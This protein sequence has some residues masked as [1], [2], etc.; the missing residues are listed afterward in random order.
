MKEYLIFNGALKLKE[1]VKVSP[2]N[3]GMMYGDGFFD[4]LRSYQG[5]FLLLENHFQR[6]LQTASY[7]GIEVHFGL[8]DFKFKI[9]ELLEANE[10]LEKEILVRIQ[11]WR[12]G[13]RGY[14]PSSTNGNWITSSALISSYSEF[15][16]LSL[17]NTRIIPNR[18]L[19]REFKLS[20]G[21][22]YIQ[23]AREA[24]KLGADDGIMLTIDE[25]I[26]ETTSANLFWVKGNTV[27]TPSIGCDL[28][29][30]I[31]RNL[32]VRLVSENPE[33]ELQEGEFNLEELMSAEAVFTTNSIREIR[34]VDSINETKFSIT[35]N[36]LSSIN[37]LF[38][39]FK[40]QDLK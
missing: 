37:T 9:L 40:R 11:C 38:E 20:N 3:R 39:G 33:L 1:E 35:H 32:I 36:T 18:A 4:T 22:N 21:L 16:K 29:P 8:E 27:Y 13:E 10:Q 28:L 5:K 19:E 26:S 24:S 2:L 7:L 25:K 31:T 14:L 12:E 30:G 23:A 15:L 34:I 6:I 17:V